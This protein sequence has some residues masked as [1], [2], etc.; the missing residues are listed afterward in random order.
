MK[1]RYLFINCLILSLLFFAM[2]NHFA[3]QLLF[4]IEASSLTGYLP[5][6]E[7]EVIDRDYLE[8]FVSDQDL[9]DSLKEEYDSFILVKKYGTMFGIY[10]YH[11]DWKLPLSSGTYF[12]SEQ[13]ASHQRYYISNKRSEGERVGIPLAENQYTYVNLLSMDT[14]YNDYQ[15]TMRMNTYYIN[16]QLSNSQLFTG[17]YAVTEL[18]SGYDWLFV[19]FFLLGTIQIFITSFQQ[20]RLTISVKKLCGYQNRKLYLAFILPLLGILLGSAAAGIGLFLLMHQELYHLEIFQSRLW[21]A[22]WQV[23]G[24]IIPLF[25]VFCLVIIAKINRV[26]VADLLREV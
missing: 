3:R 4:E 5:Y 18:D 8:Q 25:L 12:T 15:P 24:M 21:E 20:H 13:F 17:S 23:V 11:A 1:K 26:T 22:E 19:G 7:A 14:T 16:R 6:G 2:T 10:A 9:I